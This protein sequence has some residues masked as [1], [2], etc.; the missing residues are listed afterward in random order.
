M[1]SAMVYV[2]GALLVKRAS[3]LGVGIWQSAV[4]FNLISAVIYSNLFFLAGT[5][6]WNLLWQPA[7]VGVLFFGG[8]LLTFVSLKKGDVSVATPVLGS[9]IILVAI[10]STFI[11]SAGVKP[12][13]WLASILAV[14]AIALLN[15]TGKA[16]R[17]AGITILSGVGAAACYALFDVLVKTWAP[18]WGFGKFLP[19]TILFNALWTLCILPFFRVSLHSVPTASWKW[20]ALGSLLISLQS[21]L[22]I[23]TIFT[24]GDVTSVNIV[25]SSRGFWSVVAV[26][27][28]GH[29]FHNKEQQLA[30]RILQLR[31]VGA[32]LM[33][34]AIALVFL[35]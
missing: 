20:L 8:Q 13:L 15:W 18:A 28:I 21:L 2:I 12:T 3:E 34:A 17:Q 30:G 25:Y 6:H 22:F 5:V 7:L 26:W 27:L 10:F 4:V 14:V 35:A 19:L 9:K 23:F 1:V 32:L 33:M 24:F 11:L 29:W 31:M 16:H